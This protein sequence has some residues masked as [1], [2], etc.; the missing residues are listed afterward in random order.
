MNLNKVCANCGEGNIKVIGV[1]GFNGG[2]CRLSVKVGNYRTILYNMKSKLMV[3][4]L[5]D[6]TLGMSKNKPSDFSNMPIN[7]IKII[8]RV[9]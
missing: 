9:N 8:L 4:V 5:I 1:F 2:L 7:G 6:D 3:K